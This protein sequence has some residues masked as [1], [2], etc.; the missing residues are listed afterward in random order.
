M[1]ILWTRDAAMQPP[2]IKPADV[3][4]AA[5]EGRTGSGADAGHGAVGAR[6]SSA[7]TKAAGLTHLTLSN[8]ERRV[9]E[10]D[11]P[12]TSNATSSYPNRTG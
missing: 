11:L 10:A 12:A 4:M 2:Q 9:I 6:T 5:D 8:E 3:R 1:M 7:A